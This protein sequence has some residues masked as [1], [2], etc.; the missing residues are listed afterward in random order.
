M[1]IGETGKPCVIAVDGPAGAGKSTV[2]RAV[3]ARLGYI[4]VD[5][6]AMYRAVALLAL[7]H[8]IPTSDAA[9]LLAVLERSELRLAPQTPGEPNRVFLGDEDVTEAI[10]LPEVNAKV[11]QVAQHAAVRERMVALQRQWARDGGIVMDG[12]DIGTVVLPDADVKVFLVADIDVRARRRWDE[13]QAKGLDVTYDAIRRQLQERDQHDATRQESP[14][15][16]AVDAVEIDTSH[17]EIP[18]VVEEIL[19]LCD[20]KA[21]TVKGTTRNS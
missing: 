16:K 18:A 9:G 7:R 11:S 2:A 20:A 19:K 8:C 1:S 13:M 17:K 15:R 14:L 12:R 5:T 10:R 3:A 6:G 21:K 4:Y